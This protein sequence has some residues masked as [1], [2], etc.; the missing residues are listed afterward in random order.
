MLTQTLNPQQIQDF[1]QDGYLVAPAMYDA[2]EMAAL[3]K[4]IEEIVVWTP[5]KGK[6]MVYYEQDLLNPQ[7]RILSRIEKFSEYH[8]KIWE[9]VHAPKLLGAVNDLLGED[10]LLFKDKINFKLSGG[11]GF[12]PHQ[13]IQPGWDDYAPYFISVLITIDASTIENGCLELA[14]GLHKN[15]LI[16]RKWLPL[17]GKELDGI[18]FVKAPMNPGDVAFFDCYAP[19]QS[20]PNLT[21]HP[22]RNLYLTYNRKSDGDHR[23]RYFADKRKS[24]PPDNERKPGTAYTFRV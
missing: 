8:P 10:S 24:Y 12:K 15:G 22:R 4:W 13:D 17:E 9:L 3:T 1:Q 20:G 6:Q 23:E 21:K 2:H 7:K 11:D 5:E 16:G 19:H 18:D 14:S